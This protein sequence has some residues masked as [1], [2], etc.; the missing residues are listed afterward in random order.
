MANLPEL[1]EG[2]RWRLVKDFLIKEPKLLL[3]KKIW[4]GWKKVADSYIGISVWKDLDVATKWA[5]DRIINQWKG[6]DQAEGHY[7]VIE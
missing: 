3:E 5:A 7:G 6:R 1:P 4:R 2:Y